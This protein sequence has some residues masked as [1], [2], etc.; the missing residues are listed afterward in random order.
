MAGFE[1]VIKTLFEYDRFDPVPE[2]AKLLSDFEKA[3]PDVKKQAELREQISFDSL[4]DN[5]AG[6]TNSTKKAAASEK[7]KGM[8][9]TI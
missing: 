7:Q 9:K 1:H 2:M 3:Y 6:K 5:V 4:S 8:G